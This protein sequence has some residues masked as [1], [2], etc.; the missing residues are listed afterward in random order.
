VLVPLFHL[1]SREFFGG[2]GTGKMGGVLGDRN[3]CFIR[4]RSMRRG[5]GDDDDDD[6]ESHVC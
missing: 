1:L 2:G 6:D 4:G 5:S 3:L